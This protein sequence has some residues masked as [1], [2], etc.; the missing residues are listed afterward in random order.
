VDIGNGIIVDRTHPL[1]VA[2][3]EQGGHDVAFR[4][5]IRTSSHLD[6]VSACTDNDFTGRQIAEHVFGHYL[7]LEVLVLGSICYVAGK[8]YLLEL[9]PQQVTDAT[10]SMTPKG[11]VA[12]YRVPAVCTVKLSDG[13]NL[14]LQDRVPVYQLGFEEAYPISAK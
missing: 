6:K 7:S 11:T 5:G 4:K 1:A 12:W 9:V 2:L 8:P 10:A 3:V 13:V 14:L